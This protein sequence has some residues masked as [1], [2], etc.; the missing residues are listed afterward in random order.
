MDYPVVL[1]SA[2]DEKCPTMEPVDLFGN[3]DLFLLDFRLKTNRQVTCSSL[4]LLHLWACL[5]DTERLD[6]ERV[7][8]AWKN[9]RLIHFPHESRV[10]YK[11]QIRARAFS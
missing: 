1:Y 8:S 3:Q 10:S 9:L 5:P 6:P 11:K 7:D 4:C 2:D